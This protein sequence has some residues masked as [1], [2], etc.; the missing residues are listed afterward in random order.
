MTA[1][2]VNK[3]ITSN[4]IGIANPNG[5]IMY[6]THESD[7]D[8]P[9]L[10]PSARRV[11][12]VPDLKSLSLLSMGQLCDAGCVVN[13]DAKT[14]TVE[15]SNKRIM[16][17]TRTPDTG[18]WQLNLIDPPPA[19]LEP[20]SEPPFLHQSFSAVHSATLAELV[21]F[22]HATLFS[23]ALSTLDMALTR[24]FLPQFM[25]LTNKTLRKYPPTSVAMV[26]GH[27]D[28]ARK[29]QR[30]TKTTTHTPPPSSD[31]DDHP[32]IDAFPLSDPGKSRSHH[33]FA[34]VVDA[35]T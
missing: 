24:G 33:C 8:L 16:D 11:H 32:P 26:K 20:T 17:G 22:A 18:L 2:V 31:S 13:F 28:Q 25:G 15:L 35:A 21:A 23:P 29:N 4:P 6:S 5:T 9:N 19:I 27:L 14:V 1:A 3:R 7:L 10:P 30:S 34:A 12:I